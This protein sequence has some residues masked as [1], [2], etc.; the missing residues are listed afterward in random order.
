MKSEGNG[1]VLVV[2]GGAS[3][4]YALLGDMLAEAA[5]QNNWAGIIIH[6]AVR[7][8]EILNSLSFSVKALGSCP[9][10]S[11][12]KDEGQLNIPIHI[13]NTAIHPDNWVYAD[14]DGIIV[15]KYKLD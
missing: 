12:K 15:S 8:T 10:K 6:G 3:L 4:R 13:E 2:D 7:D 5:M 9:R 1:K 14:S 11:V